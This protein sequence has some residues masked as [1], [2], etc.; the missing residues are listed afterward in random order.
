M[1]HLFLDVGYDQA[2]ILDGCD[3][4]FLGFANLTDDVLIEARVLNPVTR[5]GKLQSLSF[6]GTFY[7]NGQALV[8]YK[9]HIRFIH[10]RLLKRYEKQ[11]S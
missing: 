10:E 2:F 4:H 11:M 1:P 7:Q 6:D 5:K 8:R 3:M 9:S